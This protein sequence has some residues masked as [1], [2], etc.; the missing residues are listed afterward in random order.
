MTSQNPGPREAAVAL[1]ALGPERAATILR[2]LGEQ[3]ARRLA[4]EV[5]A[6]GPVEPAEV[7]ATLAQLSTGLKSPALLPAP[8]PRMAKDLLVRALGPEVG[9]AMGEGLD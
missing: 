7:R 9:G 1:V 8:G 6:L 4:A 3:E 2:S 5:A